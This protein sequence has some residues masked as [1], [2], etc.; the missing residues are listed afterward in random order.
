MLRE[1]EGCPEA[2]RA[3]YPGL[4]GAG[5]QADQNQNGPGY[6]E[7]ETTPG[8]GQQ[9]HQQHPESTEQ[10]LCSRGRQEGLIHML[11]NITV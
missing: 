8:P 1:H 5:P 3:G 10:Q 2:G 4:S 9:E 11:L 6:E 7:L